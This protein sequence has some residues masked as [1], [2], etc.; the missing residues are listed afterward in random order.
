MFTRKPTQATKINN[1]VKAVP[2]KIKLK[3]VSNYQQRPAVKERVV[4]GLEVTV[5][6]AFEAWKEWAFSYSDLEETTINK[7]IEDLEQWFSRGF[8]SRSVVVFDEK[9]I[10]EYVNDPSTVS[11][12]TR[13]LRLAAIKNFCNFLDAK[14]WVPRDP[15]RLV[16]VRMKKLS[17]EQK[18]VKPAEPFTHTE[19][20]H[21]VSSFSSLAL[22]GSEHKRKRAFFWLYAVNLSYWTGLRFGDV[23][24]LEWSC[25]S[26]NELIVWTDKKD[27]RVALPLEHELLGAGQLF[28]VMLTIPAYHHQ[29]VFPEEREIYNDYRKQHLFPTDFGRKMK[30]FGLADKSFHGLRHSFVTRLAQAGESLESIGKLVGHSSTKTTNIYNHAK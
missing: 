1:E 11:V 23:V 7:Y 10:H 19:Y 28:E 26:N 27:K 8:N 5:R 22:H 30:R 13:R 21:V 24:C 25:F 17:H 14:K 15:S 18:E 12:S 29:F 2:H 20:K 3:K 9:L 4:E 6:E 16:K